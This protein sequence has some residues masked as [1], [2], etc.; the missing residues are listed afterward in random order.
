VARYLTFRTVA[1]V[2]R[3]LGMGRGQGHGA[4]YLPWFYVHEVPSRGRSHKPIGLASGGRTQHLLSDLEWSCNT[5][6]EYLHG[7]RDIREQFPLLPYRC[8]VPV[9]RAFGIRHPIYARNVPKVVT[10]DLCVDIAIPSNSDNVHEIAVACKYKKDLR[11][12]SV[13]ESLALECATNEALG[14]RWFKVDEDTI[15]KQ[16]HKN[17][18][19]L[20]HGARLPKHLEDPVSVARFV[21][22]F[23]AIHDSESPLIELLNECSAKVRHPYADAVWFFKYA[24]WHHIISVDLF[25]PIRLLHSVQLLEGPEHGLELITAAA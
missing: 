19:W 16:V 6:F 17:L 23:S 14:R 20:R 24:C 18:I 25:T 2:E 5:V 13:R 11:E 4:G 8:T 7:V 21:D 15:P 12:E 10:S 1:D 9:A 3:R 22:A